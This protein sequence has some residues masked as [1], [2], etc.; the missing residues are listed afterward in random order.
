MRSRIPR[1]KK[2]TNKQQ[3]SQNVGFANSGDQ[4]V[5]NDCCCWW[6]IWDFPYL[7]TK[8]DSINCHFISPKTL[9][10]GKITQIIK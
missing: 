5:V 2:G 9:H 8:G 6:R 3:K 10:I 1:I 4:E 7:V